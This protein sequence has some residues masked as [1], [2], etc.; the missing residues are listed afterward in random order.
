MDDWKVKPHHILQG[1][2][3]KTFDV[4]RGRREEERKVSDAQSL[5]RVQGFDPDLN[6]PDA[7]IVP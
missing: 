1:I 5:C 6:D 2:S 7:F 4:R 3:W